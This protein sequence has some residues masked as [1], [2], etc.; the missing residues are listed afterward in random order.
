MHNKISP[1]D[2]R[3][4]RAAIDN[5][6]TALGQKREKI[7]EA[8]LALQRVCPHQ[9]HREGLCLDCGGSAVASSTRPDRR[10]SAETESS[11]WLEKALGIDDRPND[12]DGE[13]ETVLE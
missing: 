7:H 10:R 1:D 4:T 6:L 5:E 12:D 13:Q 2:A 3:R 8:I 11:D 9:R